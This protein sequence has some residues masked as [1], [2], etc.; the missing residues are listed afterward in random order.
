MSDFIAVAAPAVVLVQTAFGV[1]QPGTSITPNATQQSQ[2]STVFQT[3]PLVA[4]QPSLSTAVVQ[5]GGQGPQGIPG[6]AGSTG[7]QGQQGPQ[8]IQGPQGPAG[9]SFTVPG[10]TV[11]GD[12]VLWNNAT[13]SALAD[14]TPTQATAKL[15]IFTTS[16]QGLVPGS[17]GGTTNFLRADGTWSAPPGGGSVAGPGSSTVGH[18]ALWNNTTGTLLADAAMSGDGTLSSSGVLTVTKLSS[19]ANGYIFVD[20][21]GSILSDGVAHIAPGHDSVVGNGSTDDAT[22]IYNIINAHNEIVITPGTYKINTAK[23]FPAGKKIRFINGAQFNVSALIDFSGSIVEAPCNAQIF[24]TNGSSS[25]VSGL[26]LSYPEWFGAARNGS[27]NDAVALNAAFY[28]IL[29]STT[30]A[31]SIGGY[32]ECILSS[33]TYFAGAQLV[34]SPPGSAQSFRIRGNG[35][36]PGVGTSTQIIFS[37]SIPSGN[38]AFALGNAGNYDVHL[39]DIRLINQTANSGAG[40]GLWISSASST[41]DFQSTDICGIVIDNV[42]VS[43]FGTNVWIKDAQRIWLRRLRIYSTDSVATAVSNATSVLLSSSGPT[44]PDSFVGDIDFQHCQFNCNGGGAAVGVLISDQG[45]SGGSF[46]GIRF[47]QCTWYYNG[48]AY[49][50]AMSVT[51]ANS[52][53]NDVWVEEGCQ[54]ENQVAGGAGIAIEMFASGSNAIIQDIHV[55][56]VYM[57][58][59]GWTHQIIGNVASGGTIR[60]CYFTNNFLYNPLDEAIYLSGT[61]GSC[62][63]HV[64]NGN[65]LMLTNSYTGSNIYLENVNTAAIVG[66]T[67]QILSGTRTTGIEWNGGTVGTIVGNVT[68]ASTTSVSVTG[69]ATNIQT[70]ANQ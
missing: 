11:S 16:L 10:T 48:T 46:G 52:I 38:A 68:G 32:N 4:L 18:L 35:I 27:T 60:N 64:I 42:L 40:S 1:V 54:I 7:P 66:N 8:G 28:A 25:L 53:I 9:A 23:N 22:A 41:Q 65:S 26:R 57:N 17:G 67:A 55:N 14:A 44:F 3:I 34:V 20:G 58:G 50:L 24:N 39:S 6:V 45:N 30:S 61:G 31:N 13:G 63:E 49:A 51:G 12:F 21:S 2:P 56:H 33:G 70:A 47:D 29:N 5:T 59:Q 19:F 37:S 62:Y 36:M 43:G 15:N 69:G